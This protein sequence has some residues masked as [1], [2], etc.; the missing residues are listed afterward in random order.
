[1]YHFKD[2]SSISHFK[3]SYFSS[4]KTL[5]LAAHDIQKIHLWLHHNHKFNSICF[6]LVIIISS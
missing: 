3:T 1:M 2:N 5:H 4:N 6:S